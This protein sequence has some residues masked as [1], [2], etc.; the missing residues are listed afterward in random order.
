[1]Q[2]DLSVA[3]GRQPPEILPIGICPDAK[4]RRKPINRGARKSLFRNASIKKSLS[5]SI[6]I[7]VFLEHGKVGILEFRGM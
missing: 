4:S 2:E 6:E 1:M 7:H 3:T 5:E